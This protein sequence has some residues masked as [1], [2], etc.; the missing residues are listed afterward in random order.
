MDLVY[1]GSQIN[2]DRYRTLCDG[3][4]NNCSSDKHYL[5]Y[6]V[7]NDSDSVETD[8]VFIGDR[9]TDDNVDSFLDRS[10]KIN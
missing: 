6:I 10:I 5:Y 2:R 4:G 7:G 9:L 3:D 1:N 8:Y